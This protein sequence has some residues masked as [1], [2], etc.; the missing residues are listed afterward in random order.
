MLDKLQR[1]Q[2]PPYSDGIYFVE[3]IQ[4]WENKGLWWKVFP[5]MLDPLFSRLIKYDGIFLN[6][7][8]TKFSIKPLVRVD[9]KGV[10]EEFLTYSDMIKRKFPGYSLDDD[11]I[12]KNED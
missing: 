8:C 1:E 12:V 9:D 11:N 2:D 5:V 10:Q 4:G 7:D 6:P 3:L